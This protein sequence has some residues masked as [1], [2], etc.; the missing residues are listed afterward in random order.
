MKLIFVPAWLQSQIS[1][2]G[3]S[4]KCLATNELLGTLSNK[5]VAF[6]IFIQN[7]LQRHLPEA[8]RNDFSFLTD[9]SAFSSYDEREAKGFDHN[10]CY[11][12]SE[13]LNVQYTYEPPLDVAVNI[14][15]QLGIGE[16]PPVYPAEK[17]YLGFDLIE[18]HI[19]ANPHS[20]GNLDDIFFVMPK[21]VTQDEQIQSYDQIFDAINKVKGLKAV[22]DLK[23]F[24]YYES[25]IGDA[26][27]RFAG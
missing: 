20:L 17:R 6:Y 11:A 22:V 24:I 27:K 8:V 12:H 15:L 1:F 7:S 2:A 13:A 21:V 10:A 26:A 3:R 9:L 18:H 4:M 5:D 23:S 16:E 19:E 14:C 25:I